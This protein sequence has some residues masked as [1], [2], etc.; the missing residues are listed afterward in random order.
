MK[1]VFLEIKDCYWY[2]KEYNEVLNEVLVRYVM[3]DGPRTSL[4]YCNVNNGALITYTLSTRLTTAHFG[5][6]T[7]PQHLPPGRQNHTSG[8]IKLFGVRIVMKGRMFGLQT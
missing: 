3:G 2:D 6:L 5:T 7:P 4:T 8:L 1:Y